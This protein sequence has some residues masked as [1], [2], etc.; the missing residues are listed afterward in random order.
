MQRMQSQSRRVLLCLDV[1]ECLW[2]RRRYTW[3]EMQSRPSRLESHD[4]S[5]VLLYMVTWIPSIY[6][7]HV[8]IYTSA[9]DPMGFRSIS[10]RNFSM[11]LRK[12]T[13]VHPLDEID[14]VTQPWPGAS[15]SWKIYGPIGDHPPIKNWQH[16][17]RYYHKLSKVDKANWALTILQDIQLLFLFFSP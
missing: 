5:M 15:A 12:S 9:M 6:P 11:Q 4:G 7:S 3:Y 17:R 2:R 14:L 13:L 10:P 1:F 16:P 8:S